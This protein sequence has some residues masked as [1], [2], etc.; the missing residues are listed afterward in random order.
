MA[1]AS[2]GGCRDLHILKPIPTEKSCDLQSETR[3]VSEQ[4]LTYQ[5]NSL[6]RLR[7][8]IIYS[9]TC[10]RIY[11]KL[12]QRIF[13]C[14]E[15]SKGKWLTSA[16]FHSGYPVKFLLEGA[17]DLSYLTSKIGILIEAFN[18]HSKTYRWYLIY[19]LISFLYIKNEPTCWG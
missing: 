9:S 19:I 15:I 7:L 11:Y 18:I 1:Y 4:V 16:Y 2:L 10:K 17:Y 8:P 13:L 6:E 12:I 5:I 14:S 3:Q